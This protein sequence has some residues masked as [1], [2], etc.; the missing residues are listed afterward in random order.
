ME[1]T[2]AIPGSAIFALILES[3]PRLMLPFLLFHFWRKRTKA[4]YLPALIGLAVFIVVIPVKNLLM[5][6]FGLEDTPWVYYILS[7]SLAGVFEEC[8]RYF[9]FRK[10]LRNYDDRKHCI[11]YGI[12][13]GAVECVVSGY[14]SFQQLIVALWINGGGQDKS[15]EMLADSH[16]LVSVIF[17]LNSAM[18]FVFHIALSVVVFAAARKL[19]GRKY[20]F[21]A[22][23]FHAVSDILIAFR[24]MGKLEGLDLFLLDLPITAVLCYVAW[25]IYRELPSF[26]EG[27]SMDC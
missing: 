25:F 17:F 24:Y 5:K 15:A 11:S 7:A 14:L 26:D 8:G 13:H 18:T 6:S 19:N 20:L 1:E 9:A 23:A 22:I 3:V 10:P 4:A 21:A 12:G 27:L 16:P 2:A